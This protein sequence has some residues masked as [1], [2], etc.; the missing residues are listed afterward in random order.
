MRWRRDNTVSEPE[1]F[2]RRGIFSFCGRVIGHLPI[3]GWLR[4][5]V[6]FI[7]RQV[8]QETQGW[9]DE[10]S[11]GSPVRKLVAD[12]MVRMESE[13]PGKGTW[14]VNGS[15]ANVWVDASSLATGVVLE[16]DGNVIED[17]SWL[18]DADTVHINM[19]EL[20]AIIKGLNMALAWKLE[21]CISKQIQLQCIVGFLIR[22][23]ANHVCAL[24]R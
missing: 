17:G 20:N 18:R 14:C 22:C 7:K 10:L 16:V 4:P 15:E 13:D 6:S 8:N 24:R 23:Q 11:F 9:D 1:K 5:A 2:S 12:I 3:C 19:E 21:N